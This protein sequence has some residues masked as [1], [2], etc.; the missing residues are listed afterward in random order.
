ME[1]DKKHDT[2]DDNNQCTEHQQ[3]DWHEM[4][5][6]AV[7]DGMNMKRRYEKI[8]SESE[9]SGVRCVIEKVVS[10]LFNDISRGMNAGVDGCDILYR[11]LYNNLRLIGVEPIG[12]NIK[13]SVFDCDT[14][15]AISTSPTNNPSDDNT[16]CGLYE[17]GFFDNVDK[18][19]I[20]HAKVVVYKFVN[21]DA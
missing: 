17:Y 4:Y 5:L 21:K 8:S 6:R 1:I 10:P 11:D 16:V 15:E 12:W 7:A 20:K 9:R 19:V 2:V 3:V 18:K 13:Y 14:M